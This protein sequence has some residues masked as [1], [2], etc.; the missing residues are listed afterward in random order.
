MVNYAEIMDN[1]NTTQIIIYICFI[2][3]VISF[4][5][6]S[7]FAYEIYKINKEFKNIY[8]QINEKD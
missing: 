1:L 3:Q 8:E 4:F 7:Y 5:T 2:V 6:T